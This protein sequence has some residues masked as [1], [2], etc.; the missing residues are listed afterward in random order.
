VLANVIIFQSNAKLRVSTIPT[1]NICSV[2]QEA[3]LRKRKRDDL[4]KK[5]RID[6]RAKQKMAQGRQNRKDDSLKKA[7]GVKVL[8]PEVFASNNM[9]QHRNYVHYKRRKTAF[10]GP[11]SLDK[12]DI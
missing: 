4:D 10:N 2:Q 11:K 7:G 6:A 1:S 9:K 3:L 12:V 8:M 5:R